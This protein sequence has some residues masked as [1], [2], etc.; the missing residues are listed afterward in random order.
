MVTLKD[1]IKK[2]LSVF[3]TFVLVPS[4]RSCL[5]PEFSNAVN[6]TRERV[7]GPR[8]HT[9]S[10]GSVNREQNGGKKRQVREHRVIKAFLQCFSHH[11]KFLSLSIDTIY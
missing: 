4:T 11:S 6:I 8:I 10:V 1:W 7:R 3:E 5:D 9:T 2:S